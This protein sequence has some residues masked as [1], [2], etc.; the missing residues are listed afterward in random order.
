MRV[1]VVDDSTI[2]R[3]RL[4][5]MISGIPS[6]TIVGEAGNSFEA[7]N[8]IEEKT[9]DVVV[10]DIKIPGDSGIEV[11]KKVKKMNS[12]II[13]ILLTNY[14]LLQYKEKCI[15]YGADYFFDKSVEFSEVTEVLK[16][17]AESSTTQ[18]L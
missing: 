13:T 14:P 8:I 6:L 12:S 16:N 17:L 11:L 18:S 4:I 15:E 7:L 9:P 10:L 1:V 2:V 5:S 3:E